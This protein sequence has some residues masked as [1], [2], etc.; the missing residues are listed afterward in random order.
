MQLTRLCYITGVEMSPAD[1]HRLTIH[2]S[3]HSLFD[4]EVVRHSFVFVKIDNNCTEIYSH[5]E[6]LQARE[7]LFELLG[8]NM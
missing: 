5:K 2:T 7:R 6:S 8:Y 3:I 1:N 4:C